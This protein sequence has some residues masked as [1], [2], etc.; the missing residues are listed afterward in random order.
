MTAIIMR[1]NLEEDGPIVPPV[2]DNGQ[3][4]QYC[5]YF[6]GD[7]DVAFADSYDELM[8][9]L[10]PHYSEMSEEDKAFERI[11]LAQGAAAQ[12]QGMI[13][14]S[15]DEGAVSEEEW[16]VLAAPRSGPQPRA[17]W[18]TSDVPLVVVETSYQP[19]TDVPRP[20]SAKAS[21]ADADN[22]WWIRP[23]EEE[24]LLF[25]LHEVGYIR[26]LENTE[27]R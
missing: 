24:E 2:K 7:V 21:T 3:G 11:R 14:A 22:L 13:L 17:D 18:W 23:A 25:S 26:L 27:L 6:R 9:V 5:M 12:I 8:D 15:L 1:N 4:F 19:F 10:V 16:V 20:A